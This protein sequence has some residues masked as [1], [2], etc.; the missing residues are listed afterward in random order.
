MSKS[1]AES[2]SPDIAPTFAPTATRRWCRSRPAIFVN[3]K[4]LTKDEACAAAAA[5]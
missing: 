5:D 1:F 4:L 3:E 2:V